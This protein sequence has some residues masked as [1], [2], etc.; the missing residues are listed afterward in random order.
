MEHLRGEIARTPARL[1]AHTIGLDAQE[2]AAYQSE[3]KQMKSGSVGKSGYLKLRFSK[4]P[5]RSELVELERRVPA[6]VQK[7]LYWDEQLPELPCVTMISTAGGILQGD[8]QAHEF[9]VEAGACAHITTQSATKVQMMEDNYA[10]QYQKI[11]VEAEGYLEY[12]P[13]PMTPHRDSRFITE[14]E[15]IVDPTATVLYSEVLMPGRKYHHP[16]E[17][18]G[19]DIFSSTIRAM[20]PTQQTLFVEKYI[21]EPKKEALNVNAVMGDFEIFGNVVLLT[22]KKYHEAIL[23]RVT[24]VYDSEALL[25]YGASLLPNDAGIIFKVLG[26]DTLKVKA[27]IRDFWQISREEILGKTIQAP[28]LWRV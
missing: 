13:D 23:Q 22:P 28:F 20:T 6:L 18:F 17:L 2:M 16:D 15:I 4:G 5:Y 10:A 8:R 27:A 9:I 14:T 1:K 7:A 25:A 24:A 11:V 12:L 3:P 21:L 26:V 19:F